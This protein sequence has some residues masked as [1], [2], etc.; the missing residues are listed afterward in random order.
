MIVSQLAACT[1]SSEA[2]ASRWLDFV[3]KAMEKEEINTPYRQVCFLANVG[4]ESAYL[5]SLSENLMYRAETLIDKFGRHFPGGLAEAK[6]YAFL[7]EKIANKVYANRYGNGDEASGD[8]WKYRG[9]GLMQITFKDNFEQ[10]SDRMG[11]DLVHNP[12]LLRQPGLAAAVAAA[13][14][15]ADRGCNELADKDEFTAICRKI[16][17]APEGQEP[18]GYRARLDLYEAG[19][20]AFNI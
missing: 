20:K 1:G 10:L 12:E 6:Q 19:K 11:L 5:S 4:V 18:N 14:F 3:I 2:V 13:I 16:T 9:S 8:G 15:F 7:P 17:G